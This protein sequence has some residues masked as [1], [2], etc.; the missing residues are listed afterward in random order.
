ML[1]IWHLK[2]LFLGNLNANIS[3]EKKHFAVLFLRFLNFREEAPVLRYSLLVP[4]LVLSEVFGLS[5]VA[6][7]NSVTFR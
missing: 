6:Y 7:D 3:I 4:V 1:P 5:C 2:C